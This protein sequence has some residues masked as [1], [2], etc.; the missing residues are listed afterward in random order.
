MLWFG[1]RPKPLH[2]HFIEHS[3]FAV[4]SCRKIHRMKWVG[5]YAA[6][7]FY[8]KFNF[9]WHGMALWKQIEKKLA[10]TCNNLYI[11]LPDKDGPDVSQS[12]CNKEKKCT[13]L[14]F[15]ACIYNKYVNGIEFSLKN[16][17][18]MIRKIKNPSGRCE[19]KK[20]WSMNMYK[21]ICVEL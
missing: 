8:R 14:V 19:R 16:R 1:V 18:K 20:N 9:E 2:T 4:Y 13:A 10:N 11:N 17:I 7:K 6:N 5:R 15:I 3:M 12:T 21:Y